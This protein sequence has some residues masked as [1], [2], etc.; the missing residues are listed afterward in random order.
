M[1]IL[2]DI[3]FLASVFLTAFCMAGI[4]QGIADDAEE[5]RLKRRAMYR[6]KAYADVYRRRVQDSNR[7]ALWKAVNK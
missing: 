1:Q 5:R 4:A 6:R 7:A 2:N 3:L